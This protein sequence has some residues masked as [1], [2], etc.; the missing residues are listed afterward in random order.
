MSISQ[1]MTFRNLFGSCFQIKDSMITLKKIEIPRIQRDYA[2]G[3][4]DANAKDIRGK[5]LE[6]LFQA[7]TNKKNEPA[8]LDFIYGDISEDGVL[9]PIDGQQRLTTLF[10]LHWY[11]AKKE[12]IDKNEYAFLKNFSYETRSDSREFCQEL[13][14]RPLV[15]DT[16]EISDYIKDQ[17]WYQYEWKN[18]P[19]IQSMLVMIDAIH[20]KFKNKTDLWNLLVVEDKIRFYFLPLDEMGL[21]DDLYIK[22]NSRGKQLTLF[23]NFKAEFEEI[24]KYHADSEEIN[25]KLDIE[26]PA[27]LFPFRDEDNN[28]IDDKFMCYYHFI[29][30]ILCYQSD[31]ELEGDEFK[32]AKLLYGK[33]NDK[34]KDNVKFLKD[35]IDCW[36][37]LDI[38]A[39]FDKYFSNK[40]DTYKKGKLKLYRDEVNLFKECCDWYYD[41]DGGYRN[42]HMTDI[43]LLFSVV[44]YLI[45]KDN[46]T[47]ESFRRRIRIIRNLILNSRPDILEENMKTL[48]SESKK[49]I[50]DG[51]SIPIAKRGVPGY[52]NRQKIEER[53]KIELLNNK[54]RIENELFRLEDHDFLKGSIAIV[55]PENSDNFA[56]F[57]ILFNN[58]D[59]R[60]KLIDKALLSID[61]YTRSI[62]NS[63][64]MGLPDRWYD[65]F[66]D[67]GD[68]NEFQTRKT[69]VNTMLREFDSDEKIDDVTV[70]K[71]LNKI[72]TNY[73][74]GEKTTKDWRYYFV[75]YHKSLNKWGEEKGNYYYG[76]NE[77]G[78]EIIKFFK[79]TF[80]SLYWNV[81]LYILYYEGGE[82]NFE[83]DNSG[84]EENNYRGR[85]RL[86]NTDISIDCLPEEYIIYKKGKP[87]EHIKIEQ[88]EESIDVED[89]IK[90]GKEI[91]ENL[92]AKR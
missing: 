5:F 57:S 4:E 67:S 77:Y 59:K 2:Q 30:D 85:L 46:I 72:I 63:F 7:I 45:N 83:I 76:G 28:T 15:L 19:T 74:K 26:W 49:I 78:Y 3:R 36:C 82:E 10:L 25:H 33:D 50:L 92:L 31:K 20:N 38:T 71:K 6:T 61:N 79:K 24:I 81:Y 41:F 90:T 34:S 17:A 84:N 35:S 12:K 13:V 40:G 69:I 37:N 54:P 11:I 87:N 16:E 60:L 47:E 64:F 52:N 23:E 56:K 75:K 80:G 39:F 88:S 51:R 29:G 73:L 21:T 66:Q 53:D 65:L 42:F 9:I 86:K 89:R 44:T 22:M 68:K 32:L 18:D 1:L 91:I 8:I 27:M 43:L 62:T 14:K 48:L 55:G 70:S 58:S